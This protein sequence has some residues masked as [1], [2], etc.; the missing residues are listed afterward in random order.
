MG[1][2]LFVTAN[3][4]ETK[5]LLGNRA[6]YFEY[7]QKKSL[8]KND[9]NTYNVGKFGAYEV[10]HFELRQQASIGADAAVLS[11]NN[12]I[13]TWKPDAVILL[14][15]AFGRDNSQQSIGDILVSTEVI[16]YESGKVRNTGFIPTASR[17]ES[18]RILLSVFK[19][20]SKTWNHKVRNRKAKVH[21]G[22]IL[23]G[24]KVV[25]QQDFKQQL[26]KDFQT[27]IGGEMEGR[28]AY[29][30]CRNNNI[31][32]W[33]IVKGICDWGENKQTNDKEKL[34]LLAANSVVSFLYHIFKD[35]GAFSKLDKKKPY[36]SKKP[37][38]SSK[39]IG[40]F[41]NIGS[42]SCRLFKV[43]NNQKITEIYMHTYDARN[44]KNVDNYLNS[45][46]DVVKYIIREKIKHDVK[47]SN[48]LIKVFVDYTFNKIFD[49]QGN[50]YTKDYIT[51]F[52]KETNLYFNILTKKQT[53]ENLKK[54]LKIVP[55]E[56][57]AIIDIGTNKV[58]MLAYTGDFKMYSLPISIDEVR[59]FVKGENIPNK[60][61]DEDIN[62]I[63]NYIRNK[64]QN[65]IDGITI[66]KTYI[67]KDE[68]KFMNQAGYTLTQTDN[69]LLLT[70]TH[71]KNN[72]RSLL[73]EKDV[74]DERFEGFK[75]GHI[76]IETLLDIVN[77]QTVIPRNECSILGDMSAYVFNVV[78]SGSTH[79]DRK[80]YLIKAYKK[81]SNIGV[82]ISSPSITKSGE[83]GKQI[84]NE[85]EYEH[86]IAIDDCDVLFVCDKDGYIG[87]STM[88]E[89]FYAY[90]LKKTIAFSEKPNN[91]TIL[92]II[93]SE[94]WNAIL[95]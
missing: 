30:A 75:Y 45:I 58:D 89:I 76:I 20:Y 18:G 72:N 92:S 52:Y 26:F 69:T 55:S 39:I 36:S 31:S 7:T 16:D 2:I 9:L 81:L 95:R 83:L 66:Q 74:K 13:E 87:E 82:N 14:G 32:E 63:K 94:Q 61:R 67:I 68:L 56:N 65:E 54:V 93:P 86:L 91:D 24:D 35:Q 60:W 33:I 4:N 53:I 47:E 49:D 19:D 27:A 5:A 57:Y 48:L 59:T 17:P 22:P 71:Y 43:N 6:K 79:E 64:I 90:A 70:Q 46:I 50:V 62:K 11:I 80:E 78:M 88:C 28:G 42:T 84:T 12:A 10:V 85:T 73:Y 40:Y 51:R 34:Q 1:K 38:K 41:I 23:S 29:N 8:K 21:F 3:H 37:R 15:I 44:N 77:N 25:D